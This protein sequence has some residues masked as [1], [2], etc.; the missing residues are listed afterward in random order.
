[1]KLWITFFVELV[2]STFPDISWLKVSIVIVILD[3]LDSFIR[4]LTIGFDSHDIEQL[5]SLDH[6]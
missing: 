1:M 6:A 3:P 2:D 5:I 4:G